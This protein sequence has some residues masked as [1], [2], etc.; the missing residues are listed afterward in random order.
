MSANEPERRHSPRLEILGELGGEVMVFHAMSVKDLGVTGARV[1]TP[2]AFQLDSLHELRL[3]LDDQSIV[4]KGRV[5]HCQISDV[6]QEQLSYQAG[7][8]FVDLT[9]RAQDVIKQFLETV[10]SARRGDGD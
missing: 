9:E 5:A 7:F 6:E 4:V 8:E 3:T 2:F 10:E 1:E